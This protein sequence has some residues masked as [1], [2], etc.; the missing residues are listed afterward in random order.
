MHKWIFWRSLNEVL[1]KLLSRITPKILKL[2]VC[3]V[4]DPIL[5]Q[6]SQPIAD[7]GDRQIQQLIDQ[8][9]ITL[10]ESNGVGLAAPQ[11]GRSLQLII[12]ASHPNQRYP[13]APKMEPTAMINPEII[14]HSEETEKGWEGCLSMPMVRGLVPRYRNIEVA[15]INRQGDRQTVKLTDFVA[16]IFQHE[17]D[18]LQGKVFLDRVETNLDLVS[19]SEY[20]KIL[21]K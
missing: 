11:I 4:G 21:Q 18:H 13:H 12:I 20:Y 19:E 3:Q 2:T 1:T 16:R 15:Y 14:A 8:M 10:H 7:V 9:L 6:I 17:Y 5:R